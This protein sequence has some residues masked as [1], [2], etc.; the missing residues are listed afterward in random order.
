MSS[1]SASAASLAAALRSATE[2]LTRA[3]IADAS[4]D[5]ELLAAHILG[6]GRGAVQ[7][8]AIRGDAIDAQ[9]ARRLDELVARRETREPLQHLTGAAPFRHLELRVG[10]GVFVP[11]PETEIVA[12]LAIDAL[13]AAAS[14]APIA[15]DLGTGSGALALA[16][17]TEV[18]HSRVFA[19][20]NSVEAFV[21]ARQNFALVGADN[22]RVAFVDIERAFPELNGQVSVV[23]SN[24]P[25]VPDAAIPRDPEVRLFDPPAALYG[26]ADGLDVVRVVSRV[27]LRLAHPGGSLV[28]EHG[29]WQGA[30]IRELLTADGWRAAS[31]HP[32]LTS[33]D[34]A[35]TAIAP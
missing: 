4:V 13:S 21:W 2:R 6:T 33:R 28:I 25:Y 1:P 16:M 17:A 11:R 18:P 7:A 32:D 12:Q 29:E 3:G 30:A 31:T 14:P 35:T 19:A 23:A 10:P 26:G 24:P 8:A 34:R 5:A 27:G 15:V 20:E 9:D 22:A